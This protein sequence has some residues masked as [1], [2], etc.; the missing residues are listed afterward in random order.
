MAY[1][2]LKKQLWLLFLFLF[3]TACGFHLQGE[4]HLAPPLHRLYLKAADPYG[5]LTRYLSEYLKMSAVQL[6][7]SPEQADTIL[8]INRDDTSQE[9][10]SPNGTLQTRQY[11]LKVIVVFSIT[12]NQ[13]RPLI[14]D[15]TL[16]EER[17]ITIQSNQILGTSNEVNMYYQQMRRM[18][19]FAIMNRLAS[20]EVTQLINHGFAK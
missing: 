14:E 11:K 15:Q 18:L 4:M 8:V 10:L 17:P 9:L 7:N 1:Y 19:A 6:V 12:D 16:T 3:L 20:K 13:G 2:L 5:Y